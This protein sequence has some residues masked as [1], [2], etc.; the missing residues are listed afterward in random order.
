VNL[1]VIL[2]DDAASDVA[3]ATHWYERQRSGLG[4]EF[5][6]S[7]NSRLS[8]IE[9]APLAYAVTYRE[10][11]R[12]KLRRFPYIVYYRLL[13]DRIEVLGVLHGSRDPRVWQQRS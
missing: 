4:D 7:L 6:D 11:R 13:D 12:A 3:S 2:R 8:E 10:V 9:A 1:P 5:L